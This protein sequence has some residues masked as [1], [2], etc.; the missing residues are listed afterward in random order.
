MEESRLWRGETCGT[1]EGGEAGADTQAK[2]SDEY[3]R[4]NEKEKKVRQN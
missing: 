4:G 1:G 3:L 2:K